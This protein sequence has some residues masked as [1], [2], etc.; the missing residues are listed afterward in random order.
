MAKAMNS[1]DLCLSIQPS[2]TQ[3]LSLRTI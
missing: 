1:D 3:D 2:G